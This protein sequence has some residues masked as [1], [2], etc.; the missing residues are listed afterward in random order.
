MIDNARDGYFLAIDA[1]TTR[2]KAGL[3]GFD[4]CLHGLSSCDVDVSHSRAG[5]SEIDM[6][7]LW[8]KVCLVLRELSDR[9]PEKI[10]AILAIGV[11]GQGDGYWPVRVDG[12]P[13]GPAILWNDTRAKSLVIRSNETIDRLC[14][15]NFVTPLFPGSMPMILMWQKVALPDR[16]A[17]THKIVHCKDWLNFKLTGELVSDYSDVSIALMDVRKRVFVDELIAALDLTKERAKFPDPVP[18]CSIIGQTTATASGQTG[19]PAGIPVIAGSI[20]VAAVA[21]GLGVVKPGDACSILGTTICN[22]TVIAEKDFNEPFISGGA[23]SHVSEGNVLRFMATSSG[24][25]ALDW[26]RQEILGNEP[27]AQIE[28]WLKSILVGSERLFFHP[29]LFGERAPFNNPYATGAFFGLTASHTR[30]HLARAAYEGVVFSMLDCFENLPPIES[31]ISVGGGAARSSALCQMVSDCLGKTIVRPDYPELGLL[32]LANMMAHALGY[33][34]DY[35]W[36]KPQ[37]QISFA[38]DL[39]NQATYAR[40]YPVFKN[41]STWIQPFWES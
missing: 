4:G 12:E 5:W 26:V 25:S 39:D 36:L 32:G 18:S 22:E 19:M 29:Y 1:G 34:R 7:G 31:L 10:S 41:L 16:V 11:A 33:T 13:A 15:D 14:R 40:L 21:L 20:D 24:T 23:L 28:A 9:H 6:S 30:G 8:A 27:Y 17:Q 38:P 35:D 37:S 2:I 3:V